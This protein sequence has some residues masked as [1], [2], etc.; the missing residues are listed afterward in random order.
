MTSKTILVAITVLMLSSCGESEEERMAREKAEQDSVRAASVRKEEKSFED[1][2]VNV[3]KTPEQESN[4][5]TSAP[6]DGS[7][8]PGVK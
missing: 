7:G 1:S 3:A 6:L 2:M 4:D 8:N 5:S